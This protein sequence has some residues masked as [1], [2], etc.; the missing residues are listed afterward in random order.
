MAYDQIWYEYPKHNGDQKT[1][2][3]ISLLLQ[4]DLGASIQ[5]IDFTIKFGHL[6]CHWYH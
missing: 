4:F 1:A 5:Q 6:Q 3:V 2:H